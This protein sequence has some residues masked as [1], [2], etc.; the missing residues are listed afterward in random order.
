L[1][2]LVV[3][4]KLLEIVIK[5]KLLG[6]NTVKGAMGTKIKILFQKLHMTRVVFVLVYNLK[7]CIFGTFLI[8]TF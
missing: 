5:I 1:E 4:K 3:T 2:L 7:I 8:T 6:E